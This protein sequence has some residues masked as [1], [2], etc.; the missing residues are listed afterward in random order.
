MS[1]ASASKG[2]TSQ[3]ETPHSASSSRDARWSTHATLRASS[4]RSICRLRGASSRGP[5]E[6]SRL[7]L[8]CCGASASL[9]PGL[10]LPPPRFR[11]H[12]L[13]RL[14]LLSRLYFLVLIHTIHTQLPRVHLPHGRAQGAAHKG[15][16]P[17][18]RLHGC[19]AVPHQ[20][21]GAQ[22]EGLRRLCERESDEMG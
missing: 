5:R 3:H 15:G 18:Q 17:R 2:P 11:S 21:Q 10:P 19:G 9:A 7:A 1:L 12:P 20:P 16:D 13:T 14:T 6:S 22:R 4:G 8:T